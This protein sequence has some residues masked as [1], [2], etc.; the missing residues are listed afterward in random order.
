MRENK[1]NFF[2]GGV[3]NGYYRHLSENIRKYQLT[4]VMAAAKKVGVVN[5]CVSTE[6]GLVR[7]RSVNRFSISGS[8]FLRFNFILLSV[9]RFRFS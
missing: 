8:R 1:L 9:D 7:L 4:A 5:N 2:G 6:A 3:T